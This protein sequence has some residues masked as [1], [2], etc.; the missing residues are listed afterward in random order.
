MSYIEGF[1]NE[2]I[3]EKMRLFV[4]T[5]KNQKKQRIV[6]FKNE[7][8]FRAFYGFCVAVSSDIRLGEP[9]ELN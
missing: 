7:I 1:K 5:V 8:V 9:I 3:A 2:E 6:Y 4:Q